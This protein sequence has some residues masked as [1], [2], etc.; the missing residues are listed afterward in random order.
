MVQVILRSNLIALLLVI[1]C[2]PVSGHERTLVIFAD[3]A[4]TDNA[5][6]D[7]DDCL[8]VEALRRTDTVHILAVVAAGGNA[9]AQRSYGLGLSKFPDLLV[10]PGSHP[11]AKRSG[12]THHRVA[13]LIKQGRG[14]VSFL[15]LSPATDL[16]RLVNFHAE[17]SRV[18]HREVSHL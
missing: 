13:K 8:A 12:T 15:V 11:G 2:A 14:D 4:C 1:L 17:V 6:G 16:A 3:F 9:S 10:L 5:A 7:P 18:F